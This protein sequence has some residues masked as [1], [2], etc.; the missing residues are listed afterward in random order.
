MESAR[1]G[2]HTHRSDFFHLGLRLETQMSSD[3]SSMDGV[4][5]ILSSSSFK[6]FVIHKA[7]NETCTIILQT[8]SC[9]AAFDCNAP[10]PLHESPPRNEP[11]HRI[12]D[13]GLHIKLPTEIAAKQESNIFPPSFL[14]QLQ[15][16]QHS[17][18]VQL[19]ITTL[20][21]LSFV[22]RRRFH[23]F[24]TGASKLQA[25]LIGWWEAHLD[26]HDERLVTLTHTKSTCLQL[27]T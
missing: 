20:A 8:K 19:F 3:L 9:C 2:V 14:P 13:L 17:S 22:N 18:T 21:P 7:I 10:S 15:L 16:C 12:Y 27:L 5:L 6:C 25:L 23:S 11:L 26:E 24:R 1:Y 4:F